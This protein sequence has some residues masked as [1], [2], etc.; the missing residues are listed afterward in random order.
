MGVIRFRTFEEA[1][2][3]LWTFEPDNEYFEQVRS[4]FEL[5]ERLCR[6]SPQPGVTMYR[7]IEEKNRAV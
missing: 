7:S 1:E 2:Q 4:T 6:L 3:A 5:A